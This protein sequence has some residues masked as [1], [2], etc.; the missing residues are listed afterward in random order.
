MTD[1]ESDK[2]SAQTR[3]TQLVSSGS[4]D[5]SPGPGVL[6]LVL[7]IKLLHLTCHGASIS[8]HLAGPLADS[9]IRLP[10]D[11]MN[12]DYLESKARVSHLLCGLGKI[13]YNPFEL[14]FPRLQTG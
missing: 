5:P 4:W 8:Q 6:F 10:A 14:Q 2:R 11:R 9:Q 13:A 7:T 1:E 12:E 3:I